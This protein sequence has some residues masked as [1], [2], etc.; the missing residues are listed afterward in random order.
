MKGKHDS[1]FT[2]RF[3][4]GSLS[5][6]ILRESVR[7]YGFTECGE[8]LCFLDCLCDVYPD[9]SALLWLREKTGECLRNHDNGTDYF[10]DLRTLESEL[11]YALSV[12]N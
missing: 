12:I 9:R 11:E 5:R 4:G 2:Y 10:R 7:H 8:M 3:Y 1:V 6:E